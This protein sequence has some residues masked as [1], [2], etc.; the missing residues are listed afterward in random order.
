[1][2]LD[3]RPRPGLW[4][5]LPH[6]VVD[7]ATLAA[8]VRAYAATCAGAE[9]AIPQ[10]QLLTAAAALDGCSPGDAAAMRRVVETLDWYATVAPA[11]PVLAERRIW[12]SIGHAVDLI[13]DHVDWGCGPGS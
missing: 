5:P 4:L 11:G 1:M 8:H 13:A 3:V 7:A 10:R 6:H 12:E 2:R 9:G